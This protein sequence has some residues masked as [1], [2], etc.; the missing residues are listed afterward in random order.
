M[1]TGLEVVAPADLDA[2]AL[3][4]AAWRGMAIRVAPLDQHR[5]PSAYEPLLELLD[6]TVR[7]PADPLAAGNLSAP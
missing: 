3:A 6:E 5:T 2:V 4:V 7:Q 1:T